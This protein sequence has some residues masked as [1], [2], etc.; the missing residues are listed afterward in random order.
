VKI[1][2]VTE[3]SSDERLM[4][5]L[6]HGSILLPM[7]GIFVPTI[8]WMTQRNKS[9]FVRFHALQAL[10][11]QLFQVVYQTV[12]SFLGG[13]AA[14]LMVTI[15]AIIGIPLLNEDTFFVVMMAGQFIFLGGF[16]LSLF[17][18]GVPGII[19]AI[20]ILARKEFHY[21]LAGRRMRKF[22]EEDPELEPG[23]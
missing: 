13:I 10:V 20:L 18:Y 17:F 21:P 3:T 1:P 2:L 4:A 12:I 6:S 9:A 5:A 7:I 15:I 8:V 16:F 11:Y 22:L 14:S 19:G 23:V